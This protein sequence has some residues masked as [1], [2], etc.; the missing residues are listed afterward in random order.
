M[1]RVASGLE[2]VVGGDVRL[3]AGARLG[4]LANPTAV[5]QEYRHAADL[6]AAMSGLKL[7]ALFGPEHGLRG[8]AQDMISVDAARDAFENV[9]RASDAHQVTRLVFW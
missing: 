6:L 8:D 2:R 1:A 3:P 5:D 4:I 7:C 9:D